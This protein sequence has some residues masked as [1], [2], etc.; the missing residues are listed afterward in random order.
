MT[1]GSKFNLFLIIG[2]TA[3]TS[4]AAMVAEPATIE[5]H[6]LTLERRSTAAISLAFM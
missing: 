2:L 1:A 6:G 4:S 5:I 3:A